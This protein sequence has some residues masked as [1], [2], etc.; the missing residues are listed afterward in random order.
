MYHNTKKKFLN[1]KIKI[2]KKKK[3]NKIT[4]IA[5]RNKLDPVLRVIWCASIFNKYKNHNIILFTSKKFHFF[6]KFF[7]NFGV[8]KIIYT[9]L[10]KNLFNIFFCNIINLVKSIILYLYYSIKGIDQFIDVFSV[11]EIKIGTNI[12]ESFIKKNHYFSDKDFLLPMFYLKYIFF[13]YVL[14]NKIEKFI[15]QNNVKNIIVNKSQYFAIDSILFLIGKK[16]KIKTIMLNQEKIL[17]SKKF[18]MHELFYTIKT[19]DLKKNISKKIIDKFINKRFKGMTDVDARNTYF[20][21][22]LLKKK[23][24]H[25]FFNKKRKK[26]VLFCPHAFSDSPGAGGKF[27]FRDFYDYFEKSILQ[28]G[29]IDSINWIVKL[30]PTRFLYGEEGVGEKLIEK[31]KFNNIFIIPDQYSTTSIIKLVDAVVSGTG[32][33]IPEATIMGK[34]TLAY[35]NSRFKNLNIYIKYKNKIDY[36]KKLSFKNLN[37]NVSNADKQLG[38]KILYVLHKKVFNNKDKLLIDPRR[39]NKIEVEKLN[40]KLVKNL[41]KKREKIIFN[42]YYYKKLIKELL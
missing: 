11:N 42:S 16:H 18:T 34:K 1:L 17:I 14:I 40:L 12:H 26:T 19:S 15:I 33:I 9:D 13:S 27:L 38:K 41:H 29:R 39:K 32:T 24:F 37:L 5:N 3:S 30:H 4:I 35:T 22:N 6:N 23:S 25:K 20:N 28:M 2:I 21:K 31:Y 10:K 8:E 36:F 7:S